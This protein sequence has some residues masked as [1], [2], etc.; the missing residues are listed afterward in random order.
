MKRTI[1]KSL[2]LFLALAMTFAMPVIAFAGP[3]EASEEAQA[4]GGAGGTNLNT[5]NATDFLKSQGNGAFD[6]V[7][8]QVKDTAAS[9]TNLVYIIAVALVVITLL[10]GFAILGLGDAKKRA[11]AKDKIIWVCIAAFGVG[12]TT[13]I[14]GKLIEAGGKLG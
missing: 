2:A 14:V 3:T 10:I 1:R 8:N 4:G 13:V 7:T 6:G 11:E 5:S 9:F 12:A